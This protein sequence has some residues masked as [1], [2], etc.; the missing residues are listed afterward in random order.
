MAPRSW[1]WILAL[2]PLVGCNSSSRSRPRDDSTTPSAQVDGVSSSAYGVPSQPEPS[3]GPV[4]LDQ[5]WDYET[6]MQWAFTSQG[7]R[8]LPYEWFLALEKPESEE[9]VRSNVNL[10]DRLRFIR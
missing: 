7:S 9:L 4:Y 6:R 3:G 10:V 8:I 2:L 1:G 5:N